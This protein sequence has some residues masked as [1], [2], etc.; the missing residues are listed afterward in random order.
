MFVWVLLVLL[1]YVNGILSIHFLVNGVVMFV[2]FIQSKYFFKYVY[3][4]FNHGLEGVFGFV[5]ICDCLEFW[6]YKLYF[7]VN[8]V[9]VY[10]NPTMLVL[11]IIEI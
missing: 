5:I 3:R 7:C 10:F 1:F 6:L 2:K 8:S 9:Y 4:F 11:L